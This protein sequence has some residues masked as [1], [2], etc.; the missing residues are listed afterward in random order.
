MRATVGSDMSRI[1]ASILAGAVGVGLLVAPGASADKEP[2]ETYET[3]T[4]TATGD[5]L[6]GSIALK[7]AL[8]EGV[9]GDVLRI[10]NASSS[11][12][13]VVAERSGLFSFTIPPRGDARWVLSAGTHHLFGPAHPDLMQARVRVSPEAELRKRV[14]RTK[15]RRTGARSRRVRRTAVVRW[16][17]EE[18]EGLRFDVQRRKGRRGEWQMWREGTT[19]TSGRWRVGAG[20]SWRVRVRTRSGDGTGGWSPS[21]AVVP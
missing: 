13:H 10:A 11:Y 17:V 4:V 18:R 21:A 20:D 16:A 8:T 1:S 3:L 2:E 6:L 12:T 5:P 9:V 19:K 14:V 15:S 7:Q